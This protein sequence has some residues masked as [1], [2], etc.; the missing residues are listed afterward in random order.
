[1]IVPHPSS[2]LSAQPWDNTLLNAELLEGSHHEMI[3]T[4]LDIQY[5]HETHI[6]AKEENGDSSMTDKLMVCV[7][8]IA[9]NDPTDVGWGVFG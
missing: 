4:K 6:H 7:D 5:W 8:S 3:S 9:G 1:L 2:H